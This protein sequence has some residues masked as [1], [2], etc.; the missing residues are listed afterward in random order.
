MIKIKKKLINSI[1]FR[2]K[3][4]NHQFI[5]LNI[6]DHKIKYIQI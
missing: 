5:Y 2:K 4:N 3:L 1:T 6:L